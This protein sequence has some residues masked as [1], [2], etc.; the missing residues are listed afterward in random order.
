MKLFCK[1]NLFQDIRMV[2]VSDDHSEARLFG[3]YCS[4]CNKHWNGWT[5]RL[6][7]YYYNKTDLRSKISKCLKILK[8]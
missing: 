3:I 1:H 8:G 4:K 2:Q 7:H 5:D 6:S